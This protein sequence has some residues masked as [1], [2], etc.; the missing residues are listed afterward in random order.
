MVLA[1]CVA[2]SCFG[3]AN[4]AIYSA[5]RLICCAGEDGYLPS[6]FG[7]LHTE[8]LTPLRALLFHGFLCS[9]YITIG[10]FTWLILFKGNVEWSW[11]F[12]R[13]QPNRLI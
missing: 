7:K 8:R 3:A 12:V 11:Y 2:A 10:D 9:F 6:S 5:A 13:I 1:V 4:S